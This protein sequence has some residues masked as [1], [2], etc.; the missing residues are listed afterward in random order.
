M[1]RLGKQDK[2]KEALRTALNFAKQTLNF[3]ATAFL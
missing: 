1:T 3:K 2:S